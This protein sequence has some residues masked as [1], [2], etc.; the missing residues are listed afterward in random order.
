VARLWPPLKNWEWRA[1]GRHVKTSA[2]RT[3]KTKTHVLE[4]PVLVVFEV[5][6]GAR[7]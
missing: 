3:S 7:F 6:C 1:Y 5:A 2:K 4:T